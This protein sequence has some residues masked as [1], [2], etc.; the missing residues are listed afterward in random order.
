VPKVSAGILLHRR[1]P[2]DG[3]IEV[4]LIYPGGPYWTNKNRGAWSI[5]KGE[6]EEGEEPLACALRE[7]EE[8]LGTRLELSEDEL[9]ELGEVRQRGG[10]YVLCW[11]AEADFD[12]ATLVSNTFTMEWPRGSG[13]EQEFPEV[14]RAEWFDLEQAQRMIN[15]AQAAFLERLLE[16]GLYSP[17][18]G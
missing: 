2:D 15:Q 7:F 12:P 10:K 13:V 3:A 17:G 14:E 1:T 18:D 8:E 4:L 9:L 6:V 16:S 11:A 5:P